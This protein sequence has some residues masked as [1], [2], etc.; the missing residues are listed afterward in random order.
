MGRAD[1]PDTNQ[2][3]QRKSQEATN[4]DAARDRN[5]TVRLE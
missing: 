3:W 1:A 5:L 2:P 4:P